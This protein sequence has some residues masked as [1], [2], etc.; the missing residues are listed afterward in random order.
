MSEPGLEQ[1]LSEVSKQWEEAQKTIAA[2]A[3]ATV[4]LKKTI[5]DQKKTIERSHEDL[6]DA[7]ADFKELKLQYVDFNWIYTTHMENKK[8][9]LFYM[10]EKAFTLSEAFCKYAGHLRDCGYP[11]ESCTCG[12]QELELVGVKK[13]GE[14]YPIGLNSKP[15]QSKG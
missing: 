13:N 10:T 12:M 2:L 11:D 5:E 8:L 15:V 1:Q 4:E 14:L 7:K 3:A 9:E 6:N